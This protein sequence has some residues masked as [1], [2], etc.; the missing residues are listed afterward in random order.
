MKL[1]VLIAATLCFLA[2]PACAADP[3]AA[4][5]R[6][7]HVWLAPCKENDKQRQQLC[8]SNQRN[9]IEQ[10]VWAKAGSLSSMGSTVASFL[11]TDASNPL[12]LGMPQSL[13]QSCAWQAVR[14]QSTRG[15]VASERALMLEICRKLTPNEIAAADDRAEQLLR[16]LRT[17]PARLP[18]SN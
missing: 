7:A 18:P 2:P 1:A 13:M 12:H 17:T 10:Y 11:P 14:M 4:A 16:E 8:L 9:F 15:Q 6:E 3:N 5:E